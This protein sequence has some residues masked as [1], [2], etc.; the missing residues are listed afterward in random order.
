MERRKKALKR[1]N[2]IIGISCAA[3]VFVILTIV[4]AVGLSDSRPVDETFF[5]P[6]DNKLVMSIGSNIASFE[7]SEYEPEITRIVYD[8]N[9]KDITGMKIYFEYD[10][11]EDARNAYENI[12]VDDKDWANNKR[13]SG[14][15][16]VFNAKPDQYEGFSVEEMEKIINGMEAAG[17]LTVE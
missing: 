2:K 7:D 5:E 9:G 3:V 15:Y 14:K 12:S 8:H 13:I 11:I 6:G 10:T 16:I 1:R 17:A 4:I